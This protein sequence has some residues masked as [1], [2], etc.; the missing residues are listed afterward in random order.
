MNIFFSGLSFCF[1]SHPPI[2]L[3]LPPP[4]PLLSK[5]KRKKKRKK[6]KLQGNKLQDR[7]DNDK[8]ADILIHIFI[9]E[10]VTNPYECCRFIIIIII[11]LDL[12]QTCN[13]SCPQRALHSHILYCT[14]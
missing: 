10:S 8:L 13:L 3:F 14:Y 7:R 6:E 9:V 1:C 11:M 2:S 4:P 5:K 12:H